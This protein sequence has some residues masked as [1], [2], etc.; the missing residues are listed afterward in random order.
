MLKYNLKKWFLDKYSPTPEKVT[1]YYYVSNLS[2]CGM[3]LTIS[4][5]DTF[6]V[7][8]Y[9]PARWLYVKNISADGLRIKIFKK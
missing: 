6:F 4:K 3:K 9:L 5:M 8:K 1:D 7:P 2:L